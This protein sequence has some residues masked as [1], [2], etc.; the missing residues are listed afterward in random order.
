[1]MRT[2]LLKLSKLRELD[3]YKGDMD[4]VLQ[5]LGMERKENIRQCIRCIY[6]TVIIC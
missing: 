4:D 1:M 6:G 5:I 3:A 2:S